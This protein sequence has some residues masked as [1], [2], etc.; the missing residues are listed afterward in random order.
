MLLCVAVVLRTGDGWSY[1]LTEEDILWLGRATFAEGGDRAANVWTWLSRLARFRSPSTIADIVRTH[2]QPVNPR[3]ARG[4]EFCGPGGQY[5]GTEHCTEA[6]LAARDAHVR[7][8]PD[9]WDD[10][11]RRV[12][13]LL[14]AG[15]L[16]NPVPG[17]IDF[18]RRDV[19][20]AFVARNPGTSI[21][22][23]AGNCYVAD[24]V[25]SRWPAGWVRLDAGLSSTGL[26]MRTLFG[27]TLIGGLG[28]YAWR[29]W[30]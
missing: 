25:S 13:A 14:R 12:I 28:Y 17:A 4:G 11:T 24:S 29:R 15:R 27:A 21:I 16:P 20:E 30:G 26:F 18:A 10:E 19:A 23:C 8:M 2:A 9:Q 7:R 22:R 1:T 5:V 6:R 3:W